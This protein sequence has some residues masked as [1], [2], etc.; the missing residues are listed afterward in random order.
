MKCKTGFKI[1]FDFRI[2]KENKRKNTWTTNG[3]ATARNE[4]TNCTAD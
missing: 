1:N 4:G 2:Q 3:M